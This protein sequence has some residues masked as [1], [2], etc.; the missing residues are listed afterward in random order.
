MKEPLALAYAVL[1]GLGAGTGHVAIALQFQPCHPLAGHITGRSH[2]AVLHNATAICIS[3]L[4]LGSPSTPHMLL[5]SPSVLAK[6]LS[7][8]LFLWS[9]QKALK[10]NGQPLFLL[11]FR[12]EAH[13]LCCSSSALPEHPQAKR[14]RLAFPTA[15]YKALDTSGQ[16]SLST[17]F[18][19]TTLAL[20][21]P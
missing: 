10:R 1:K 4:P 14:I 15:W 19:G 11:C 17:D 3:L 7:P 8:L 20:K 16:K 18:S 21:H 9:M 12:H 2:G 6:L 13:C 5:E